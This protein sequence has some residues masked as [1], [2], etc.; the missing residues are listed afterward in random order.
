MVS[1]MNAFKWTFAVAALAVPASVMAAERRFLVGD[2]DRVQIEG[3]YQVTLATGRSSSARATGGQSALD[4]V[5]VEVRG[6][7]LHVRASRSAW[8]GDPREATGPVRIEITTR[9]L[10]AGTV[11]GAASLAIDRAGGLR[12]DFSLSGSGRLAI[13]SV[14]ADLLVVGLLG[15]GKILLA[16]KAK[17][18]RASIQGTG[19]L[20]AARFRAEDADIGADTAGAI[21]VTALRTAR[22][23]ANGTG[24]VTISGSPACT[25]TGLSAGG[26]RCG[27]Q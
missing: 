11:A 24:E 13:A 5:S 23:R 27:P 2:F 8:G 21:A 18:L 12:L 9:E 14:D 17:Q 15:S 16:G 25:V 6:R 10:R 3:P 19:D 22:V 7:T 1:A 26:V 20:D 4:R